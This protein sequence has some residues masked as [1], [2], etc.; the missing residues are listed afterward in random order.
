[1]KNC[2]VSLMLGLVLVFSFLT[3]GVKAELKWPQALKSGPAL[4]SYLEERSVG[5]YVAISGEHVYPDTG[6]STWVVVPEASG[7]ASAVRNVSLSASFDPQYPDF[8]TRVQ[9]YDIDGN[10]TIYGYESVTAEENNGVW[11]IPTSVTLRVPN[12]AVAL[13]LPSDEDIY[14]VC[15]KIYDSKGQ[16]VGYRNCEIFTAQS[17]QKYIWY[18]GW[19]TGDQLALNNQTAELQATVSDGQGGYYTTVVDP[20]T[21]SEKVTDSKVELGLNPIIEGREYLAPN[22]NISVII[23]STNS[24]GINPLYQLPITQSITVTVKAKTSEGEVSV[25]FW[26]RRLAQDDKG[27]DIEWQSSPAGYIHLEP[28]VYDIWFEWVNFHE[29]VPQQM[30]D[31]YGEKG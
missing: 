11:T 5:A 15:V 19:I 30:W 9:Y 24:V 18:P 6:N 20:S 26:Y 25:R 17:G 16:L 4:R 8:W 22:Q 14:A 7:L 1:M 13:P 12:Y 23:A 27:G 21:G 28:G 3:T 2:F 10:V 29:V 31:Y